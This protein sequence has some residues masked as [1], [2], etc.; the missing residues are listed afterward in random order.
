MDYIDND[1]ENGDSFGF[2]IVFYVG[3]RLFGVYCVLFVVRSLFFKKKF[4]VEWKYW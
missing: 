1:R 3:G 4:G 2:D